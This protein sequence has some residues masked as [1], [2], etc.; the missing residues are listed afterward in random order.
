MSLEFQTTFAVPPTPAPNVTVENVTFP[1]RDMQVAGH[2]YTPKERPAGKK[3]SAIVVGHPFLGIKEQTSGL[4]AALLAELGYVALAYDATHYGESGGQPR[5]E[6]VPSDRVED[7]SAAIDFLT[8]LD[9]VDPERIGVVGVCASGGYSIAATQ[10]EA[11]IKA[12]ATVSMFNMGRVHR[13]EMGDP[14]ELLAAV[15]ANRTSVANGGEVEYLRPLPTEVDENTPHLFKTFVDYYDSPR[16]QHPRNTGRYTV[17]SAARLINFFPLAQIETIS[18]RPLL[19]IVG[20]NAESRYYTDEAF[21]KAAEPKELFVVP[22]AGHVD[23]YDQPQYMAVSMQKLD[24]FFAK[25]LG[26]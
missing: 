15:G 20:E 16:G 4:H 9:Y 7:F 24:D 26:S 17:A 6:E 21:E 8:T 2:L 11:R 10:Q 23:L 13:Q 18:P 19:M 5:E 14:K 3:Y 25:H 1:N 22:G 12:I